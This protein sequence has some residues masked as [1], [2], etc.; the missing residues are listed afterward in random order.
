[1]R[2]QSNS[3][4]SANH[5]SFSTIPMSLIRTFSMML[6]EMDFV[7]T[8]V[9]PFY[10]HQL[11]FPMPAFVMLCKIAFGTCSHGRLGI[12]ANTPASHPQASSWC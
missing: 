7:G 2:P 6:G 4:Q 12:N 9:Q 10:A 3:K 5:L 8:Y 11:T 1:M